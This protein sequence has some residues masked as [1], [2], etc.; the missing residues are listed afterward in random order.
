[1]RNFIEPPPFDPV[2]L[3]PVVFGAP[4]NPP[5][6]TPPGRGINPADFEE[7]FEAAPE[8]GEVALGTAE[9]VPVVAEAAPVVAEGAA[10]LGL[11]EAGE[12]A[13]VFFGLGGR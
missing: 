5:V 8:V 11:A 6:L 10:A 3:E 7:A 4:H 2:P 12:A 13:L 9:S 1:M